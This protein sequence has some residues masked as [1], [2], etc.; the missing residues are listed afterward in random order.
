MDSIVHP[1]PP[2]DTDLSSVSTGEI[3]L[4]SGGGLTLWSVPTPRG[5]ADTARELRLQPDRPAVVGRQEGG[6]IE[7]L[8]PHYQ[9]TRLVPETGQSVMTHG[10]GGAE[11]NGKGTRMRGTAWRASPQRPSGSAMMR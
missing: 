8:D 5:C 4:L 9:P 11:A 6:A 10:G 1:S 7:Y 3:A 2:A